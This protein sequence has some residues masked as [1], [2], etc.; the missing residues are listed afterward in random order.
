MILLPHYYELTATPSAFPELFIDFINSIFQDPVE[1]RDNAIIVRSQEDDLEDIAWAIDAFCSELSKRLDVSIEVTC[2]IVQKANEDWIKTYQ[3]SVKPIA[4]ASFYVHPSWNEPMDDKMNI[5]IDPALAFGSG[6]HPTTATCLEAI[7]TLV[8][9]EDE[10]LDVGCGSGILS[11]AAAFKK[12]KVDACDTDEVSVEQTLEN[13]AKNGVKIRKI[14][15]GSVGEATQQYDVIIANIVADVLGFIARDIYKQLKPD[16]IAILSG[17][18]DKYEQNV[19][20]SYKN[21]KHINRIP[22]EEWVT[23]VVQK[24]Q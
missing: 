16:G 5:V 21:F 9:A 12:G 7:D 1:E 10:V 17:I 3:E 13:S 2:K 6:H 22:Q 11:I 8:K 4:I 18:L 20:K 23:L 14:W 15:T 19:L 24:E